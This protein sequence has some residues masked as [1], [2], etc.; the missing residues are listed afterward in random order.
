[1]HL[2][3]AAPADAAAIADI[4]APIVESTAISFEEVVPSVDEMRARIEN[5]LRGY[6]WIVAEDDG[7]VLGYAYGGR[8]RERRAYRWSVEVTAY[9]HSSAQR[10]GV[11]RAVYGA[12][13][14]VL[15]AQGFRRAL[16]GI[17]LPNDA[18]IAL[19]TAMGMTPVGI[20]REVGFKF[21]AWHDVE[22]FERALA[23]GGGVPREPIPLANL[24]PAVAMDALRLNS[25]RRD[26]QEGGL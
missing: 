2:R 20:Y 19:H 16:A 26:G 14:R 10:R 6:P 25:M 15:E 1:M 22:W 17:A 9:V 18:S 3:L 12:L 4:Y 8:W 5:T 11:G 21:G 23:H 24:D 7:V 13:F